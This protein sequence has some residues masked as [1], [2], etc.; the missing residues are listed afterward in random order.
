MTEGIIQIVC[1]KFYKEH[2][3]VWQYHIE[4]LEKEL[5]TEIKNNFLPSYEWDK[6]LRVL[7]GDNQE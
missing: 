4:Q 2:P 7:I 5:I 1:K 6:Q 3:S